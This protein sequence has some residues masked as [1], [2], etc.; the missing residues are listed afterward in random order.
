MASAQELKSELEWASQRGQSLAEGDNISEKWMQMGPEGS[1]FQRLNKSE[2]KHLLNYMD[3]FPGH[4]YQLNQNP[5]VTATHSTNEHMFTLIRNAGV[6]WILVL[7]YWYVFLFNI[8]AIYF[9]V[10]DELVS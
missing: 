4:V 10:S 5:S 1:F 8:F 2:R 7:I 9:V 3:A 6:L